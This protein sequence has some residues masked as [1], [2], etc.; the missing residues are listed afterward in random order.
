MKILLSAA[1]VLTLSTTL[2][3][4]SFEAKTTMRD[5]MNDLAGVMKVL[6]DGDDQYVV[7]DVQGDFCH[8]V[9]ISA[10][11]LGL[12]PLEAGRIAGLHAANKVVQKIKVECIGSALPETASV[13]DWDLFKLGFSIGGDLRVREAVQG[14]GDH[15]QRDG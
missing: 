3:A 7:A 11:Y 13:E 15:K 12:D 1:I 10:A 5:L 8:Q 2:L 9:M 6:K 4:R 14:G